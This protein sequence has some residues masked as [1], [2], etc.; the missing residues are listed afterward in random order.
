[1]ENK[2]RILDRLGQ[3]EDHEKEQGDDAEEEQPGGQVPCFE[4]T[5]QLIDLRDLR[6]DRALFH[7]TSA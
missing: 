3:G 5:F 1:M 4:I 2:I 6:L 7:D